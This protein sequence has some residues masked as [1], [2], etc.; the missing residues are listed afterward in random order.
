MTINTSVYG[1]AVPLLYG[2]HKCAPKLIWMG[3]MIWANA[4]GKKGAQKL[5]GGG[6]YNYWVPCDFLLCH[7]PLWAV[8]TAWSNKSVYNVIACDDDYTIV[9]GG[10]NGWGQITHGIP[11]GFVD[12]VLACALNNVPASGVIGG[13]SVSFDDFGGDGVVTYSATN[14]RRP[15][16]NWGNFPPDPASSSDN[17][18]S[19]YAPYVY[20][21]AGQSDP[22][23]V[24]FHPSLIGQSVRVY[25]SRQETAQN[26]PNCL[27][28]ETEW[29]LGNDNAGG[30][31]TG[32]P[33]I[34][35][36][37]SG[38]GSPKF[39]MGQTPTFPMM[40][41]EV[42]GSMAQTSEGDCNPLDIIAD[43]IT[44]G[45]TYTDLGGATFA[46]GPKPEKG[47]ARRMYS[48]NT[49]KVP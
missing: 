28:L 24:Y 18:Y 11:S 8:L 13:G 23:H 41:F 39:F 38:V 36:W 29:Y 20:S 44:S 17:G 2:R 3:G 7:S 1:T 46:C 21:W 40:A 6:T 49:F 48:H 47:C 34:Y 25:W 43:L 35:P 15:L 30:T 10:P 42:Q 9:S 37:C 4:G 22:T 19:R 26:P 45:A 14:Y 16:W 5:S 27:D 31:P 12:T 33:I 32:Q